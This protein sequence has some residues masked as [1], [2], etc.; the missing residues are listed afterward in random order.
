M[1]VVQMDFHPDYQIPDI[2][3]APSGGAEG[4]PFHGPEE[5][6]D[7]LKPYLVACEVIPE[8]PLFST[9]QIPAKHNQ[10][11]NRSMHCE[12]C[13]RQPRVD[14]F[15]T[16]QLSAPTASSTPTATNRHTLLTHA[17]LP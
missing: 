5:I 3:S 11:V 10:P 2:S 9:L 14:G 1:D 15:N 16:P 12:F 7:M 4:E 8:P 6:L 13:Q 17:A